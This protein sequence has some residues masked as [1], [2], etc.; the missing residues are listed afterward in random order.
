M[1]DFCVRTTNILYYH[2][3]RRWKT[4]DIDLLCK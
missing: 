3:G 2:D 1:H 4:R